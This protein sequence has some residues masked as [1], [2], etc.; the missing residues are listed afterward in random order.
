MSG[1][2]QEI[3]ESRQFPGINGSRDNFGIGKAFTD[4][5]TGKTI[6]NW[7]TWEKEGYKNPLEVT[8]NHTVREKIKRK[9]DKIK[10]YDSG[11]RAVVTV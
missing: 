1:K 6:D 10:N 2:I 4:D 3:L 5:E 7:R 9:I 11:K 8:K